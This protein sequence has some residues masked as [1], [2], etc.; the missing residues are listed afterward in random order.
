MT[1]KLHNPAITIQRRIVTQGSTHPRAI[2]K[3]SVMIS[4][5]AI[6]TTALVK[7]Q[8]TIRTESII[9]NIVKNSATTM[10]KPSSYVEPWPRRASR[11]D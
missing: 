7:K 3:R 6:N 11:F 10:P 4:T 2:P 9:I 5:V 1:P 8:T